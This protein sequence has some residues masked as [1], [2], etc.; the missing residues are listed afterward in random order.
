MADPK[1]LISELTQDPAP[2]L[3]NLMF[4]A[5]RSGTTWKLTG[6]QLSTL[7]STA[8][9]L[10]TMATQN[11]NAVNVTGGTLAGVN[12]KS[13]SLI[14]DNTDA[15]KFL[16]FS[17]S[18]FTTG[19]TRTVTWPD[20]TGTVTLIDLVQ[21]LRNKSLE[22]VSTTIV[23]TADNTKKL[24]MDVGGIS[25]GTTRVVTWPDVSFTISAFATTLLDD[26]DAATARTTLNVQT[27]NSKLTAISGLTV[28]NGKFIR[29]TSA[30]TCV[31]QDMV[32]TVSQSGGVPTG[33]I[34]ERGSNANGEY[35]RYADG[36]QICTATLGTSQT[37]ETA[38][39]NLWVSASNVTWTFPIAFSAAPIVSGSVGTVGRWLGVADP[40]TTSVDIRQYAAVTSAVAQNAKV[41][42]IGRWF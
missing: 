26:A 4:P 42:A 7:L 25:T 5:T 2:V 41:T 18:S 35:V 33:A 37:C 40:T 8:F 19:T 29:W 6:T 20:G 10:G 21:R 28:A 24:R 36:T 30:T 16:A 3:A 1:V 39:G 15:T 31:A 17:L 12:I 22:D 11:A 13:N 38:A 27:L 23:S 34:I 14:V 9:S 32:G